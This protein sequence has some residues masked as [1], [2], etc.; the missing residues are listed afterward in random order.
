MKLP[1]IEAMQTAPTG[2][3]IQLTPHLRAGVMMDAS[4]DAM[5]V[6]DRAIEFET[7]AKFSLHQIANDTREIPTLQK[8][9]INVAMHELYGPVRERLHD[10]LVM[11]WSEGPRYDDKIAV[12]VSALM[13]DLK[14]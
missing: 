1:I 13:E 8:Q 4:F 9:A 5:V 10:I 14:P 12:A 3:I 11:L 6:N 7:T 2:K